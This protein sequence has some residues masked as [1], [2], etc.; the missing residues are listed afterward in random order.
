VKHWPLFSGILWFLDLTMTIFL[1][2]IITERKL[3]K[4]VV[5]KLNFD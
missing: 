4:D 2:G 3:G 5:T 1:K